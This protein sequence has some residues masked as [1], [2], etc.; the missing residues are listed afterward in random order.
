MCV[1]SG[2][3]IYPGHGRLYHRVDGK[4][5]HFLNSKSESLFLQ[6][7]NPRKISWTV[8]YRRKHR[9]GIRQEDKKRRTRKATKFVRGIEVSILMFVCV[10]VCGEELI[11]ILF[12]A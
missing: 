2:G 4:F 11:F 8:L 7:K 1:F 3:K 5:F 10:C 6:R 12:L 9:K